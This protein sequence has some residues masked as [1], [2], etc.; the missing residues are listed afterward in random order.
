MA[1]I[2][3]DGNG[4]G[5]RL[6]RWKMKTGAPNG[7][8]MADKVRQEM[9]V[10]EFFYTMRVAVR[11]A[12]VGAV[13]KTFQDWTEPTLPYQFLMLGGDD[14]LLICRPCF[15]FKFLVEYALGLRA[16]KLADGQPL[17]IGAGVAIAS[18]H[19]P[20]HRLH[21][22]AEALAGSA[23]RLSRAVSP[24]ISTVDWQVV[25]QSWTED[26]AA[27][28]RRESHPVYRGAEGVEQLALSGRP[29]AILGEDGLQGL[30]TRVEKVREIERTDRENSAAR[31]QL[32]ALPAALRAGRLHGELAFRCL[33]P[34]TR[35]VLEGVGYQ[36]TPWR[37]VDRDS[38]AGSDPG[39]EQRS[40]HRYGSDLVDLIELLEIPRLGRS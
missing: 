2:H 40:H 24:A 11:R 39:R 6:N 1:V 10:E 32:R 25:T 9:H 26:P 36:D 29:Y 23:K 13:E 35:T 31:S 30:L 37:D 3:A 27:L 33:A 15:A 28:R 12:V 8:G 22:L 21:H 34:E 17:T 20:F 38:E 4:V 7:S 14:L 5:A 18:H 19:F 16:I